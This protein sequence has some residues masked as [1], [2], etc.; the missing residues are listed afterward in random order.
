MTPL[1]G[2][3]NQETAYLVN[4]YP[5]GNKRCRIRF[6]VERH[7]TRGFRFVS[8][9]ENPKTLRWNNPRQG[10]YSLMGGAMYLDDKGHVQ[11]TA[12]SEY[13]DVQAVLDFLTNFPKSPVHANL[14]AFVVGRKKMAERTT[15]GLPNISIGG[16]PILPTETDIEKA[17]EEF[18]KWE[19]CIA[20]LKAK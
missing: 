3:T 2:H 15:R 9:T 4:D 5:Y 17:K 13:S 18:T 7:Q 14:L 8:Q 10:T 19:Q 12:L 16:K 20:L 6:W 1:Y 11:Y